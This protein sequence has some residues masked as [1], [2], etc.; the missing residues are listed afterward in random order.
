MAVTVVLKRMSAQPSCAALCTWACSSSSG[1]SLCCERCVT[2]SGD[3]AGSCGTVWPASGHDG[4]G[5][6]WL[7]AQQLCMAAPACLAVPRA[8]LVT[9]CTHTRCI[10]CRC[11][12]EPAESADDGAAGPFA[13]RAAECAA[14]YSIKQCSDP[15]T[16]CCAAATASPHLGSG[17]PGPTAARLPCFHSK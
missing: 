3:T 15:M 7:C 14:M 17:P 4:A 9:H 12:S 8:A 6:S 5:Q 2:G 11:Q 1:S 10:H 16:A 13:A